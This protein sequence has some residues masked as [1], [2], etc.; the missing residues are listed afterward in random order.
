MSGL[1]V[2]LQRQTAVLSENVAFSVILTDTKGQPLSKSFSVQ[3][4]E[5]N[6]K[7][8]VFGITVL[9]SIQENLNKHENMRC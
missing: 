8:N 3:C 2:C 5:N 9:F 7:K 4:G 1:I 6:F